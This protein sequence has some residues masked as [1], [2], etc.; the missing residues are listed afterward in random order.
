M[1]KILITGGAGFIGSNVARRLVQEGLEVTILD[2]FHQ[3]IHGAN[4]SLPEDLAEKV[5]LI[6]ASVTNKDAFYAALDGQ[7]AVIH[8]AAETGTGQSMY[9]VS[10]YTEVNIQ[11][12]SLLCDYIIN[13][14]HNLSAVVVA[15]SRSIYGEGKYLSEEFGSVYPKGRTQISNGNSFEVTCPLS[16]QDN[17]TLVAT[18]EESK[19]HP[20]SFYGITKQVQEQ[21]IILACKLKGINGFALRYQNVYGPGQSLKNPYTGILSIFSRLALKNNDINIFEDGNESR[22][23]VYID[24]VVDATVSCLLKNITGQ[25]ILNVGS[26]VA[27][28]VN[29]VATEIVSFLKSDS[30]LIIS[31][32]FRE[33]DIRHNYAD[34]SLVNQ[35]LGFEPKW[36]F[37]DG[38]H[39]FLR[40]VLQ[41]TDIP[42][43]VNDY[44]KSLDELKQRGLLNG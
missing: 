8:Y 21:M 36:K 28:T 7:D 19:I 31:G 13:E 14:P 11:A 15:S 27:T 6:K 43:N 9:D 2:N 41:Q 39:Q 5:K 42:D 16:G 35:V 10:R 37:K 26:G 32:T 38:L 18:D 34:L 3:Q 4:D 20:S 40:W 24:D 23:F 12:T 29:E 17:L 30:K 1:K 44:K 22:D 33:G 25:H